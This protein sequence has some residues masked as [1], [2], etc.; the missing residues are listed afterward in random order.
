MSRIDD[1]VRELCPEGV[2]KVG[3]RDLMTRGKGVPVTAAQMKTLIMGN[4]RVRVFAGGQTYVDVDSNS[5]VGNMAHQ[6][7]GIIVRSRGIIAFTFWD[8]L[9]TH[10]NELWSY[11]PKND[12]VDIKFVYY[13]V[14]SQTQQFIDL[15]K[16]KSVKMPQL[17]VDD[18][19]LYRIPVPP[20]RYKR[21]LSRFL[22]NSLS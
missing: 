22:T 6:G 2:P 3:I 5:S 14:S 21:K 16:S 20:L 8:G 17:T 12:S 13:L 4:A 1:L 10:K 9:F 7:P 15:A 18:T 19:D 11:L